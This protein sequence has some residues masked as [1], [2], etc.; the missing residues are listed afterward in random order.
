MTA[1][2]L[3][4]TWKPRRK[5]TY[6]Y[7]CIKGVIWRYI[8]ILHVIISH[9]VQRVHLN[10][11]SPGILKSLLCSI[12]H[13]SDRCGSR[14][15]RH[16]T[17]TVCSRTETHVSDEVVFLFFK[18]VQRTYLEIIEWVLCLMSF[19]GFP[20]NPLTLMTKVISFMQFLSRYMCVNPLARRRAGR[21]Q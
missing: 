21:I 20:P 1:C 2:S 17:L 13:D 4:Q 15:H 10:L 7:H 18:C 16:D 3:K 6:F 11:L 19:F 5:T 9:I 12:P 14:R 8:L